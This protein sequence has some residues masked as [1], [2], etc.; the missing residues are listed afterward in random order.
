MMKYSSSSYAG[1]KSS[2]SISAKDETTF[3]KRAVNSISLSEAM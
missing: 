2:I 1:R 3:G